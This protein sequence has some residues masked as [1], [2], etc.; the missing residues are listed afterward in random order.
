[1]ALN[2][3]TVDL[4][5]A[6]SIEW[7]YTAASICGGTMGILCE[8][9]AL[10]LNAARCSS[11]AELSHENCPLDHMMS[12]KERENTYVHKTVAE[13]FNIS[14]KKPEAKAFPILSFFSLIMSS[15]QEIPAYTRNQ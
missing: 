6:L 3:G 5:R 11:S 7:R 4:R 1:M 15:S 13:L 9:R 8:Q 10:S 14:G 2:E 12:T